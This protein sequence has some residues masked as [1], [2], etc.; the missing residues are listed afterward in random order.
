[1]IDGDNVQLLP[2]RSLAAASERVHAR[3]PGHIAS[4]QSTPFLHLVPDDITFSNYRAIVFDP[5]NHTLLCLSPQDPRRRAEE[6]SFLQLVCPPPAQPGVSNPRCS[7]A[8]VRGA[9][10]ASEEALEIGSDFVP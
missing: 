10:R 2:P 5:Y 6:L 3:P 7:C 1:M 4:I 8:D 9:R